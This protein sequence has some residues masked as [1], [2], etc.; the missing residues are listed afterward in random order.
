MRR[1]YFVMAAFFLLPLAFARR[2]QAQFVGPPPSGYGALNVST[3]G[4]NSTQGDTP[5]VRVSETFLLHAGL[6]F[7]A[8]VDSNVSYSDTNTVSSALT[9]VMPQLALTNAGR[10]TT[11][12][13]VLNL[14]LNGDYRQYYSDTVTSD[15]AVFG[16]GAGANLDIGTQGAVTGTLFNN[17]TRDVQPAYTIGAPAFVRDVEQPGARVRWRPGGGRLEEFLTYTFMYDHWESDLLNKADVISNTI[18]FRSSFKFLP[19]TALYL[20]IN[21]AFYRYPNTGGGKVSS[22]P[23]HVMLGLVGLVTPKLTATLS[24]GYANGFYDRGPNPSTFAAAAELGFLIGP[25]ARAKLGYEHDFANSI[26]G[27]YYDLDAIYAAWNQ[28]VGS[29]FLAGLSLRYEHRDYHCPPMGS[30]LAIACYLTMGDTGDDRKDN[31]IGLGVDAHYFPRPWFSVG[32]A[33]QLLANVSDFTLNLSGTSTKV[34]FVKHQ[35]LGVVSL[36]Y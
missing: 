13:I 24:A 33:Y 31:W 18:D 23:F 30:S 1:T 7:G 4:S 2:A 17:F 26:Y 10:G 3:V 11:P 9:H 6:A 20:D 36:T 34:S 32:A 16:V 22:N 8:G 19:K 15:K 27:N 25:F 35:V 5:G 12:D 28:Q 29:S 14:V 21:Q